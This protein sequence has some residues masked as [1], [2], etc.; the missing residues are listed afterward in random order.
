[1]AADDPNGN[2][3][4]ESNIQSSAEQQ[5]TAVNDSASAKGANEVYGGSNAPYENISG[6]HKA[7]ANDSAA[8]SQGPD[9][10]LPPLG[11][12][13]TSDAKGKDKSG[14]RT[15]PGRQYAMSEAAKGSGKS[16]RCTASGQRCHGRSRKRT[17]RS[18]RC[19][20]YG[21]KAPWT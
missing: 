17:G 13:Y 2:K 8:M 11:L 16:N 12:D 20:A 15:A 1:M 9:A 21:Q 18:N 7:I 6:G 5:A 4:P 14:R 10:K 19:T 3:S